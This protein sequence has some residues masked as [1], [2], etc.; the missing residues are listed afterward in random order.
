MEDQYDE[1][2]GSANARVFIALV[3]KQQGVLFATS[4]SRHVAQLSQHSTMYQNDS[5]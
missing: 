4:T 2:I 5:S 1:Q 3:K